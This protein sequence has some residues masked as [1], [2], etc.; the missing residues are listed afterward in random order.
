MTPYQL[1]SAPRPTPITDLS[2]AQA[3]ELGLTPIPLSSFGDRKKPARNEWQKE[4]F[5]PDD[6][7]AGESVGLRTGLQRDGTYLYCLDYDHRPEQDI[8]APSLFAADWRRIPEATRA[9]LTTAK[10][11]SGRGRYIILRA[12]REVRSRK[13]LDEH[14]RKIGDFLGP[15][16]QVVAPTRE[17]IIQ[18]SL[19]TIPLLDDNELDAV[20]DAIR[21]QR[22]DELPQPSRPNPQPPTSYPATEREAIEDIKRRFDLLGY[23]VKHWPGKR[24]PERN[25][26]IRILG[27]GGFHVNEDKGVWRRFDEEC[28]GDAIDLVG[29]RLFE[30]QWNRSDFGMFRA[31]L[32][33]AGKETGVEPPPIRPPTITNAATTVPTPAVF[34][35]SDSDVVIVKREQWEKTQRELAEYRHEERVRLK[36]LRTPI[37]EDREKVTALATRNTLGA[38]L[39][40]RPHG[41]VRLSGGDAGYLTG[42]SDSTGNRA[43]R[44]LE[45]HGYVICDPTRVTLPDGKE[46]EQMRVVPGPA[47]DNPD[48]LVPI[49]TTKKRGGARKGA[50]RK[51]KCASCPPGTP[52]VEK[53]T[54]KKQIVCTGCGDVLD[55]Q[56]ETH[57]REINIDY[58]AASAADE[59]EEANAPAAAAAG[60]EINI[61]FA[62][63][64]GELDQAHALAPEP[65]I[66]IASKE[67]TVYSLRA[68]LHAAPDL[69]G[70]APSALT[71]NQDETGTS[72]ASPVTHNPDYRQP[73]QRPALV[74]TDPMQLPGVRSGAIAPDDPWIV[75]QLRL[76]A[77]A[78]TPTQPGGNHA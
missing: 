28:G 17:R 13:I 10:S 71:E 11:T 27:H 64:E 33:E 43:I 5:S 29:Y 14:G 55:E 45:Q 50:G 44:K 47:F 3:I 70:D 77:K 62:Q 7:K 68:N 31:A 35:P 23:A 18:G 16:K 42:K 76:Q 32:E 46:V 36:I 74:F 58:E 37:L 4:Q 65:E 72:Y 19:A 54:I 40:L 12:R 21:Y 1:A 66:N 30:G 2:P 61:D 73:P 26:E 49:E 20:L 60:P 25:G 53:T 75:E 24:Q 39:A 69:D 63:D 34:A 9:K 15:G 8:D 67:T 38:R 41:S 22:R 56:E 59:G 51:P 52:L 57:R 78:A 6:W 48:L